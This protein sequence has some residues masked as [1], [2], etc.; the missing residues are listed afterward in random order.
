MFRLLPHGFRNP[1]LRGLLARLLGRQPDGIKA[2][3]VTYDLRRLR[4][5]GLIN[6]VPGS[7]RYRVRPGL[8]QLTDPDPPAA[9][10]LRTAARA[11]QRELDKLTQ[12]AG[13]A[14]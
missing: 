7:H 2:G 10:T 14:A 11:Y 3:Q 1:D 9:S 4:A 8:A 6:R 13:F 12:E 5:H